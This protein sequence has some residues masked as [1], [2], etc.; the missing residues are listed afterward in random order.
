MDEQTETTEEFSLQDFVDEAYD[1]YEQTQTELKEID[2]LVKQSEAE[3]DRLAQRN[4]RVG[5]YVSQLQTNFDTIPRED[6]KEGYEALIN[7]QQRLFTMRGQLEKLQSD[8]RNL[9]RLAKFQRGVLDIVGGINELPEVRQAGPDQSNVIRVIQSEEAARQS[10]VRRMHDGPASSLSNFILQAE[11]CQRYFGS[12]PERARIELIALKG[13][14][15]STFSAVKDFIFDLRPMMLDDLGVVP[16][17]RRYAESYEEKHK[18]PVS[19]AVTGVV[20]RLEGHIE[21]TIFRAVQ[22]LLNNALVHGQASKIQV[23]LDLDSDRVLAAV[24]DDGSGFDVAT[25]MGEEPTRSTI[26]LPTLRER[27]EMLGG[28]MKIESALGKG[29]RIEFVIPVETEVLEAQTDILVR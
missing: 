13:S 15:A 3:V 9:G 7:A 1:A 29:T 24:E 8:H 4:A 5:N 21:V 12:D 25:I 17:L 26:G 2:V 18:I 14:A 20:R 11:I 27:I 6:I 10:L 16:T 19:I 23:F 22:E 28:Q